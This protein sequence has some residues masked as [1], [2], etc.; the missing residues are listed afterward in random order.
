MLQLMV[1]CCIDSELMPGSQTQNRSPQ[2]L[3]FKP[4]ILAVEGPALRVRPIMLS[5]L[6]TWL[7]GQGSDP[8][9]EPGHLANAIPLLR[10][11][12][13]LWTSAEAF[14]KKIW[15]IYYKYLITIVFTE[16]EAWWMEF[17]VYSTLQFTCN[18]M[19][20]RP[21]VK[22]LADVPQVCSLNQS[23]N[24]SDNPSINQPTTGVIY[25]S[26]NQT[27]DQLIKQATNQ[28]IN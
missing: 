22:S 19:N 27:I 10:N 2:C 9:D 28:S 8:P 26:I 14:V 17:R 16:T 1:R 20:P 12:I 15:G 13:K 6:V 5:S 18:A 7:F 21:I 24:P 23:S 3:Q 4:K 11:N 25:H